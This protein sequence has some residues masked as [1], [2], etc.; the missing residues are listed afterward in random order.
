MKRISFSALLFFLLVS[1][2][3]YSQEKSN[4]RYHAFSGTLMFGAEAGF[5]WGITDYDELKPQV[6]GRGVLEYF[7]PATSAGIFGIKGYMGAGYV[8]GKDNNQ[9]PNEFRTNIVDLGGGFSYNFSVKDAVFPYVFVGASHLWFNPRD[10]NDKSLPYSGRNFKVKEVNYHGELGARVLLS[11]AISLNFNAGIQFSPNDNLDALSPSGNN[12]YIL[13][14]RV[15]IGYSLFTEVDSDGDGV[16]DSKDQCPETPVGVRVDDFG[17]P[18]DA[19]N[20]GVPDYKDKCPGTKSG[21]EVDENGCAID[22]DS[23]GVPDKL[24]KCPNTPAG[25]KVNELGCPDTDGDGV[26]DNYDKCPDTPAGAPVDADGCPKD[27]DGDGV[28]DYKDECPNTPSGTQVDEAGC[29]KA[30]TVAVVLQGDTNFEFN[31][32]QLLPNAYPVLNELAETIK[33]TPAKRWKVEGHTDAIGS[34]SYNMDLSRRRAQAVVNYLVSQGVN[35]SQLEV[36]PLGESQPIAT[37][38]TQEGRAMN[39]RVEIKIIK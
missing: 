17:C 3:I 30:D 26:Y 24:D 12:D 7:F 19:D 33:R 28:P 38:D 34:E 35:N 31:K 14:T 37:N 18:L 39:R 9:N 8:G 36:V 20:D 4:L 16:I 10:N 2:F 22:S 25:Q 11:E 32:D 1:S 21:L 27:S 29:A 15:G 13:H 23:D 6:E 5:T